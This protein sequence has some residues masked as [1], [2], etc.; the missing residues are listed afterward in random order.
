M[1]VKAI[2]II[3]G[4]THEDFR[5]RW[6]TFGAYTT[7]KRAEAEMKNIALEVLGA[8]KSR[9]KEEPE[10]YGDMANAFWEFNHYCGYINAVTADHK[11]KHIHLQ[12]NQTRLVSGKD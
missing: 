10:E 1:S 8:Y 3:I 12:I 9:A 11:Q 4:Y 5:D 6:T 7:K 2:Y